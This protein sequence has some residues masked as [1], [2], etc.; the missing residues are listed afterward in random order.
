MIIDRMAASIA[1]GD[2]WGETTFFR[3]PLYIYTVGMLYKWFGQSPTPVILFHNLLAV[4]TTVITWLYARYLFGSRIARWAALIIALWPTLIYFTGELMITTLAVFWG[5][6]TAYATHRALDSGRKRTYLIAG[7]LLGL[8]SITRPTFLPLFLIVPL[9]HLIYSGRSRFN[10]I[11]RYGLIYL[12]GV[13]LP[14]LPVTIRNVVV[15]HDFALISTQGG[16]N[17]FIGNNRDADGKSVSMPALGPLM[18]GGKYGDNVWT[19]SVQ[20]ARQETGAYL[21]QSQ[22]SSYWFDRGLDEVIADPLHAVE[23]FFSKVYYFWH[24]QEIFNNKSPYF[25]GSYSWLM[26]V[27]LW[28]KVLNFPSGLLFPAMLVGIYFGWRERRKLAVP[29]LYLLIFSITV[30]L[31]FVCARF[32]QP[33]IPLAAILASYGISRLVGSIKQSDRRTALVAGALLLL[34]LVA[35]NAGGD[36]ESSINRSQH[37]NVIGNLYYQAGMYDQAITEFED[38]LKVNPENAAVFATLGAAYAKA[39]RMQDSE[40]TLKRALEFNPRSP[41]FHFNLGL[42]YMRTSRPQLAKGHFEKA[43]KYDPKYPEPYLALSTI[44][45]SEGKLDSALVVAKAL[46]EERPDDPRSSQRLR[47]LK[48]RIGN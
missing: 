44:L 2:F 27:L 21:K 45:E 43:I 30:S 39:N 36:I 1:N 35:L 13:L 15:A 46:L 20:I 24:G 26:R 33:I 16:V 9:Y 5:I 34:S 37:Y 42:T 7:L 8:A 31:F 23:L 38:A 41:T 10:K 17:F 29:L 47:D 48:A 22:V 19:S 12:I 3:A 4:A 28:K 6:A 18:E 25:S 11:I 40:R 32:R 14:I